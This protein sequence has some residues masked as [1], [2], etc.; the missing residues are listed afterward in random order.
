MKTHLAFFF[1]FSTVCS[2]ICLCIF[3]SIFLM[4]NCHECIDAK[5]LNEATCC[6]NVCNALTQSAL[7]GLPLSL[8]L[9]L[10]LS[11]SSQRLALALLCWGLHVSRRYKTKYIACTCRYL[12]VNVHCQFFGLVFS[13]SELCCACQIVVVV[14]VVA[15]ALCCSCSVMNNNAN[16]KSWKLICRAR[17]AAAAAASD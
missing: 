6:W 12:S 7:R 9:S 2:I 4:T 3:F 1:L 5:N 14:A 10:L 11:L 17:A 15:A 13:L 8:L 16:V